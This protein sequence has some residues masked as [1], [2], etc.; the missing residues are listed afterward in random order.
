[1]KKILSISFFFAS[2]FLITTGCEKEAEKIADFT[3]V[4]TSQALLKINFNSAYNSNP[5]VQLKV[6]DTRVSNL[7][8]GPCARRAIHHQQRSYS[9]T[10]GDHDCLHRT[11]QSGEPN[12]EADAGL[13]DM[14]WESH[15]SGVKG[16]GKSGQPTNPTISTT[17]STTK[18]M[19]TGER[20]SS[21]PQG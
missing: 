14:A 13:N 21:G 5:S 3:L 9:C 8:T 15:F 1:M 20:L 7:I 16:A 19:P 18:K 17:K 4:P 2:V 11:T 12:P 6:N 10:R